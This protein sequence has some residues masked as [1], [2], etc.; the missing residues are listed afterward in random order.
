MS[1][2]AITEV[3]AHLNLRDDDVDTDHYRRS[4]TVR[5][6]GESRGDLRADEAPTTREH[7]SRSGGGCRAAEAFGQGAALN[8][9]LTSL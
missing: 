7:P 1:S 8:F 2:L 5:G 4:T 3:E 9:A 6:G